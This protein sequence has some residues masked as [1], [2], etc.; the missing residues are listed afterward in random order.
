LKI[1]IFIVVVLVIILIV[2]YTD[3]SPH[4]SPENLKKYLAISGSYAPLLFISAFMA[5]FFLRIPGFIFIILGAVVFGKLTAVLYS[6]IA[7]TAGTSLTFFIARFFLRD[8]VSQLEI[9]G[10]KGLNKKIA[11]QGFL[12]VL[13]LRLLFFLIPPLNWMLGVTS[14]KYRDYLLG[15]LLGVSPGVIFFSFVF[16][17]VSKIDFASG[18]RDYRLFLP[19]LPGIFLLA[20]YFFFKRYVRR[21]LG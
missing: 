3:L 6:F 17:D 19:T 20:L 4:L 9:R 14:V 5:G 16:G 8:T 1:G 15:T 7:I 13:L 21:W 11:Q 12:T 10:V 18:F 2:F